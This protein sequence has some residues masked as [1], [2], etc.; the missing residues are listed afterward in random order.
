MLSPITHRAASDC[1]AFAFTT[2]VV[3]CAIASPIAADPVR[4]DPYFGEALFYAYQGSHLEALERLDAEL[5]QH[6]EIDEPSLDSLYPYLGQAEFSVGDFELRY[7]MHHRAGRAIRRVLEGDVDPATRAD[8]TYRL[9]R[10]HFQKGQLE[11]SLSTLDRIE[12]PLA[13]DLKDEV[14][15]LRANVLMS[16]GRSKEAVEVLRTLQ[17]SNS[18][19]GFA[20][21]NLGIALLEGGEPVAAAVQ[22]DRAGRIRAGDRE[23]HAIR[24]KSNLVLGSLLLEEGEFER[25]RSSLDRIRLD[26]PYS[27]QA[28][29][30]AG[31]TEATAEKFD[32]A[33][34]PWSILAKRDPTDGAVQEALL[35]LPF[36]YSKLDVHS[37]AAVLYERAATSFGDELTKLGA[38]VESI[39]NGRFLEALDGQEIREDKEWI[40]RMR[41]LPNAP[42]T[43]YLVSLM[44][45]HEFQTALQNYLDLTEMRDKLVEGKRSLG[46][47][48]QLVKERKAYYA[49]KLPGID[50]SFRRFDAQMRLRLQQRDHLDERLQKML[51]SPAPHLLA[52]AEE[53]E[54]TATIASLREKLK[55]KKESI[56]TRAAHNRLDRLEG[57]LTW[58]L[59][60]KYHERL[61]DVHNKLRELT[62]DIDAL[63][64]QYDAFVRTRQAAE[65]SYRGYDG[66]IV[67]L[68]RRAKRS[69]EQ[70]DDVKKRQGRLLEQVAIRELELRRT[71]LESYQDKARF[72]FADSYDRAIKA[73]GP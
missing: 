52:T 41:S 49:P 29:L 64:A 30:R 47:F 68:R 60:T 7:R 54:M 36:A 70:I 20:A 63:Q 53:Q 46:A 6:Y 67:D 34:V 59:E 72:A 22:L 16:L 4:R 21:Y 3:V 32:R 73:R 58:T 71:Q 23:T 35:A 56:H 18:F 14:N 26:G 40:V 42:E 11:D 9:A 10:I 65:H 39:E 48:K 1:V 51:T 55:G 27:N 33:V 5:G 43:F 2:V 37:R 38:S 61:T 15:F 12:E 19:L 25:A 17:G 8:A 62:F 57:A 50:R 45:S 13:R 66:R 31:W 44:A 28:L 69:I 24:D